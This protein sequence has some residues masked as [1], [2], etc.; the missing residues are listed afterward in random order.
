MALEVN[1]ELIDDEIIR[2]HARF[3]RSQL[4]EALE[5]RDPVDTEITIRERARDQVIA[6]ALLEQRAR[7]ESLPLEIAN[8][9]LVGI[10]NELNCVSRFRQAVLIEEAT[11]R[12]KLDQLVGKVIAR[13][14]KPK[15]REII[16][17]YGR[18][19]D[20]FEIPEMARAAHIVKSVDET[21]PET[22]AR[23]A[24]DDLAKKLAEG[25]D[26]GALADGYSDCPGDGGDLGWFPRGEMVPEFDGIVFG[27]RP[28]ELSPVFRT[29]FGFHIAKLIDR[30]PARRARLEEVYDRIESEL[31]RLRQREA[32]DRFVARLREQASIR[33][34]KNP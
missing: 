13:V 16:S 9:A 33:D 18:N 7:E 21:H 17:Y 31:H 2:R 22:M 11:A 29:T 20:Q 19:P 15:R 26:F 28:G 23:E 1:G 25:A 8:R 4:Q 30:S 10:R 34:V 3:V 24:V 32:M 14:A 27:L 12:L 5:D 6:D